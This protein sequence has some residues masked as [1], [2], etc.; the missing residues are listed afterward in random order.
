MKQIVFIVVFI[1]AN[2][3]ALG[4]TEKG[5]SVLKKAEAGDAEAQNKMYYYYIRPEEGFL[6]NEEKAVYWL[7]KSAENGYAEAQSKLGNLYEEGLCGLPEDKNKA[8][9]LY[10]K[11]VVG[12]AH[13][14]VMFS[15]AGC[16]RSINKKEAIYWYKEYMDAYYTETGKINVYA[17]EELQGLGIDYNPRKKSTSSAVNKAKTTLAEILTTKESASSSKGL[18]YKGTY[19]ISSQGYCAELGGYT[20]SFGSDFTVEIDI[21]NDYIVVAGTAPGCGRFDYVRTSGNWRIYE[22]VT[23]SW[24]S[25]Y[26]KVNSITFDMSQYCSMYNQFTGSTDTFIYAMSK[27]ETTFNKYNNDNSIINNNAYGHSSKQ[28]ITRE[29]RTC[30]ACDGK[31]WI[32]STRGVTSL[33][34][35]NKWCSECN[36]RV[37][38]NHYHES[39]PSCNGKGKW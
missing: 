39:C 2:I 9:I 25:Y 7:K 21:Y 14:N 38:A 33:G 22:G 10:L 11:A 34:Q 12:G 5:F 4:Q 31:G 29:K 23:S 15:L 28:Q 1:S 20:N 35:N 36:K 32:S 17:S 6:E 26:Y 19:T 24:G 8:L 37:P 13:M 16:Y 30:G 3:I 27:G 18:L